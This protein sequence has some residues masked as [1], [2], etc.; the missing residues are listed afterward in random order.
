MIK[1]TFHI[2]GTLKTIVS[3]AEVP[4]ADVLREQMGLTGTKVGC[5]KG[6]CGSCSVILNGKLIKSCITKLKS[7]HR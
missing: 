2:N 3:D 5:G 1:K 7:V 6:Q 4:L